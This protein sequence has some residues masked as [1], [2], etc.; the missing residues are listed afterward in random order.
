MNF[1]TLHRIQH[2]PH[3][4]GHTH[5]SLAASPRFYQSKIHLCHSK[6]IFLHKNR[7][8]PGPCPL[9]LRPLPDLDLSRLLQETPTLLEEDSPFINTC[10]KLTLTFGVLYTVP[11]AELEVELKMVHVVDLRAE[12]SYQ[13]G[14]QF[15]GSF[16]FVQIV[17]GGEEWCRRGRG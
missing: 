10:L 16:G 2:S 14:G 17:D 3:N 4:S 1:D 8:Y 12:V 13:V 11:V 15:M 6:D 5:L 7:C 9:K